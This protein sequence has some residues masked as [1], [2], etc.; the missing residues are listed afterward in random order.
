MV[1]PENDPGAKPFRF[2]VT[3]PSAYSGKLIGTGM[4]KTL[5]KGLRLKVER[6]T[7][8]TIKKVN[9]LKHEFWGID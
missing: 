8:H 3:I 2:N 5:A 4:A 7:E 6:K 1:T 9:I